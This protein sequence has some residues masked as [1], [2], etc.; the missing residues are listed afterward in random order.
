MY[1]VGLAGFS[2]NGKKYYTDDTPGA[3]T[4]TAMQSKDETK[5]TGNHTLKM[6]LT[7]ADLPAFK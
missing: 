3:I 6:T 1:K 7:T 2:F 4:N 5:Q